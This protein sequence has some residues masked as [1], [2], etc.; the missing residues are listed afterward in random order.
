M[1]EALRG[2]AAFRTLALA[3]GFAAQVMV[4]KLLP[5]RSYAVYA[6]LLAVLLVGE[7]LLSFGI[8]RTLLRFV[9][10][11]VVLAESARIRALARRVATLR[12]AGIFIFITALAVSWRWEPRI[13]S[14]EVGPHTRAVFA[15]WFLAYTLLKDF[16]ALAQSL[17]AHKWAAMTA[18]SEALLRVGYLSMVS[19]GRASLDVPDLVL[20]YATTS[21]ISVCVLIVGVVRAARATPLADT[22]ARP[23]SG[24]TGDQVASDIPIFGL[25]A[26]ASTLSYL[27]SSQ[28]VIR[29]VASTGL[30]VYALAAFSF[31][32]SLSSSL[33]SGLP[34]QLILPSLESIAAK[35][36]DSGSGAKIFPAIS[37]LFKVELTCMLAVSI[38]AGVGGRRIVAL[39]SRPAYAGYYYVLPVLMLGLLLQTV[40]R[41]AEIIGSAHLRYRVFLSLWPLSAAALVTLYFTVA[42]WGLISVLAV[43]VVELVCRVSVA[44]FA[45]RHTG[46]WR[47]LDP[48]RS[49]RIA[50][51]AV[52]VL[53]GAWYALSGFGVRPGEAG[54]GLSTGT[55]V[56]FVCGLLVIRPLSAAECDAV[57]AVVPARWT[58]PRC[59]ARW[60]SGPRSS[61]A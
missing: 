28:G 23:D 43:P 20:L 12:S 18:A 24:R 10:A 7:R 38:A 11:F 8:D 47:A 5:P 61:P 15:I 6:V 58:L 3:L 55:V 4:V 32:Q 36:T 13:G 48:R 25:A 51:L 33:A 21:T 22:P 57:S 56:I 9:P 60:L 29:L 14:A 41:I 31:L 19:A 44:A 35:L 50:G 59:V 49:V 39:L 37:V 16:E 26:Y 45:L 34:G 46:V 30:L 1:G 54:L 52:L 2:H 17:I 42:R 40:Y 53:A 27:I